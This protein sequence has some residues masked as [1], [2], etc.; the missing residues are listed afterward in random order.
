MNHHV[1]SFVEENLNQKISFSIFFK[2][3][4]PVL[5]HGV[6]KGKTIDH[7]YNIENCLKPIV[8]EIWKQKRSAGTKS[9]KLL[10]DNTRPHTHSDVLN[11]L[12]EES[13]LIIPHPSYSL[14]LAPC[15]Y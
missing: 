1:L 6:D 12:T 9:I 3:N 4:G 5:I 2:S 8:K 7:N 13:I 11:Y 10:Y 15:D 14:D